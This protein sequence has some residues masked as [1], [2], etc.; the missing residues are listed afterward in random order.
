MAQQLY[1]TL[2]ECTGVSNKVATECTLFIV[3]WKQTISEG[4]KP[5]SLSYVIDKHYFINSN[6]LTKCSF[7]LN[8]LNDIPRYVLFH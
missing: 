3:Y 7:S 6:Y 4:H 1:W 8:I 2:L 5:W